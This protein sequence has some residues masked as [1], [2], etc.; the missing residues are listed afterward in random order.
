MFELIRLFY[1]IILFKK[2]PQDVP[3][4]LLFTRVT[5][6]VYALINFLMLFMSSPWFVALLQTGVDVLLLMAFTRISL[7]WVNKSARY[8]QT[9]CALLG[10]DALITFAAFPATAVMLVP[11]GEIAV[12][13]FFVIVSLMLWH[14]SVIGYILHH[15]LEQ[16]LG[17]SL[18]LALLYTMGAYWLMGFLFPVLNVNQ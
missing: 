9:F 16:P 14:W 6:A 4:S 11:S 15:A 17:F 1:D 2:A 5:L 3:F 8:Q 18:G 10:T 13:G 12:L 7:A